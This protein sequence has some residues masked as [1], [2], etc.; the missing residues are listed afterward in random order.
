MTIN[1]NNFTKNE[2]ST[3]T[4]YIQLERFTPRE[5]ELMTKNLD[6]LQQD[7]NYLAK[8]FGPG[9]KEFSFPIH[10]P[11]IIAKTFGKVP[12]T[13]RQASVEDITLNVRN[14]LQHFDDFIQEPPDQEE[15]KRYWQ[16]NETNKRLMS[17]MIKCG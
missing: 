16:I 12:G 5:K 4:R 10:V 3:Y 9:K 2:L 14:L 15:A 17:L 6:E 1:C 11:H 13:G 8:Y 7:R